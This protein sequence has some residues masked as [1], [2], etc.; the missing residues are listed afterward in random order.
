MI[1]PSNISSNN[2]L[3][4]FAKIKIELEFINRHR[5]KLKYE[6]IKKIL[7][8]RFSEVSLE[9]DFNKNKSGSSNDVAAMM[10]KLFFVKFYESYEM[11][12]AGEE[13]QIR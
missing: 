1:N 2:E 7:K 10:K 8:E 9:L 4:E 13:N 11:K 3:F 5:S 12:H 6:K